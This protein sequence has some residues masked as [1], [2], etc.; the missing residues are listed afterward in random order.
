MAASMLAAPSC[1]FFLM[2]HQCT[3]AG[4]G[5]V[6]SRAQRGGQA[7]VRRCSAVNIMPRSATRYWTGGMMHA[8]GGCASTH[9]VCPGPEGLLP[10]PRWSGLAWRLYRLLLGECTFQ[11]LLRREQDV[12]SKQAAASAAASAA[13]I[14]CCSG[15]AASSAI[16]F[17]TRARCRHRAAANGSLPQPPHTW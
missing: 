7:A 11:V 15:P 10:T 12:A 8:H 3:R 14:H 4:W 5:G 2:S 6:K 16:D 17:T 1:C 13:A 9:S